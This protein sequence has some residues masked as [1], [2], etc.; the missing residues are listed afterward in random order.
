MSVRAPLLSSFQR[1]ITPWLRDGPPIFL[2]PRLSYAPLR[3]QNSSFSTSP[4]LTQRKHHGDR[5][6]NRGVSSLRRKPPAKPLSISRIVRV[7]GLPKPVLDPK[8]RSKVQVD[9]K[10]G[11]YGFFNEDKKLL[12]EPG[13]EAAHGRAWTPEELRHK[14]WEDIHS[15]WWMCCK[16]RNRIATEKR[17]R[18]RLNLSKGDGAAKRRDMTIRKTQ[19]AIKHALTERWYAWE[20]AWQQA[21]KDPEIDLDSGDLETPIYKPID[22]CLFPVIRHQSL[23]HLQDVT[24]SP[25][26]APT[27][28]SGPA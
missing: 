13:V 12:T 2:A 22:V 10:H 3:T 18:R 20:D 27:S 7:E 11:L 24:P 25:S 5:N 6:P 16:E 14:S 1:A 9:P 21:Q 23:I 26:A 28:S 19:K 8:R 17:E 15:L 4:S